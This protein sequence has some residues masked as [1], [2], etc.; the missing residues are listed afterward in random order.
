MMFIKNK[1]NYILK[2]DK[3]NRIEKDINELDS[4]PKGIY[5]KNKFNENEQAY[6]IK[7]VVDKDIINIDKIFATIPDVITFLIIL[8]YCYPENPPKILC[9]TNVSK[10]KIY[11]L[12]LNYIC[13]VLFSKFNGWKRFI[14]K[15]IIKM[16]S[17]IF[18]IGNSKNN[19][20]IY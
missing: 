4:L 2:K 20:C 12:L 13:I 8:D 11:I 5:A 7:I 10:N 9:Q 1:K 16:D 18:L 6:F 3:K 17:R 14:S 19:S 15:H